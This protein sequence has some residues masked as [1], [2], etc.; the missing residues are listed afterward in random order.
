[1]K[2]FNTEQ[3]KAI[4]PKLFSN[5]RRIFGV[6]KLPPLLPADLDKRREDLSIYSSV[7]SDDEKQLLGF[8]TMAITTD[9]YYRDLVAGKAFEERF[10]LWDGEDTPMLFLRHLVINDRRAVPYLMRYALGDL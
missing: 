1:M 9:A 6:S 10:E 3:S 8:F 5:D 7:F 4:L 2:I